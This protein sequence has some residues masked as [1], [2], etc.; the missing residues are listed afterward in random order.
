MNHH[1]GFDRARAALPLIA[2]LR[3][4]R[5]D[6]ALDIGMALAN[7][8][9]TLI[10]VPLNS[11][12]PLSSIERLAAGLP[13]AL[14]GAGTVLGAAQVREVHA[15]GGNLVVAPNMDTAVIAEA[16]RLG[17]ACLPGIATPTEAFTALAAGAHGLKLFPAEAA[18]PRVLKAMR[19]VLPT[20]TPVFPVGGI[21]AAGM[22]PWRDAGATGFGLGSALYRPGSSAAAVASCAAE[23]VATWRGLLRA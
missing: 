1:P 5:P 6:E 4:V 16:L 12:E 19:A 18:S 11:P 14:V 15:A 22:A 3:G 7:A 8:G 2:I 9:L 17:M 23:F 20:D 21:D 13:D 10:E